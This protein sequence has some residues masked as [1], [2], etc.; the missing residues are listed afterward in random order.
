[1]NR[2]NYTKEQL[3]DVIGSYLGMIIHSGDEF[4][5]VVLSDIK[6][7]CKAVLK[8]NGYTGRYAALLDEQAAYTEVKEKATDKYAVSTPIGVFNV[9]TGSEILNYMNAGFTLHHKCEG[10]AILSDG[11]NCIAVSIPD[12]NKY[13]IVRKPEERIKTPRGTFVLVEGEDVRKYKDAGYGMHHHHGQ[14]YV[15][16]NGVRA[17]AITDKDYKKYYLEW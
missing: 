4:P 9:A 14:Y 7:S 10:H 16:G 17:V 6:A 13:F 15:I 8:A 12:Y 3:L 5:A 1:M 2:N 11:E